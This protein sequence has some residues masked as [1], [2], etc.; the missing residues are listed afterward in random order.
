M[1]AEWPWSPSNDHNPDANPLDENGYPY[2]EE[3]KSFEALSDAIARHFEKLERQVKKERED[4]TEEDVRAEEADR[5]REMERKA[6]W[7][8]FD[9]KRAEKRKAAKKAAHKEQQKEEKEG[10]PRPL[11]Q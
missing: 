4:M 10:S 6:Y 5:K 3:S 2:F 8:E 7:A 9:R 11:T 1:G